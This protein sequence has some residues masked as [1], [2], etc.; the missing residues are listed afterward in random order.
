M[1]YRTPGLGREEL[2]ALGEVDA[3]RRKLRFSTAEPR[4]WVGTVRRVLAAR[5]IQA[6]NSIEGYHLSVEDAIA[7]VDGDEPADPRSVEARAVS[8]YQRAMTYV[9][10]LAADDHFAY[11][12]DLLRSL[13]F[14]IAEYARDAW[15]GRWRP[16]PI[17]VRDSTSGDAVYEA[18]EADGVPGLVDELVGSLEV[19]DGSPAPVRAAMAHLNLVMIHPFRDGNGRMSRCL[20]TLVLAREGTLA[21]E[22]ISIEEYLGR[23]TSRYYAVLAEVGR[24]SWR[25]DGDARGWVRFCLEAHY[26]QAASVLRRIEESGRIWAEIETLRSVRSLP[27]RSTEALFDATIGLQVRNAAY[28]AVLGRRGEQISQ[29]VATNDLRALVEAGLLV[30]HGRNRG[31]Y[32]VA[33]EPLRALYVAV[34][35]GRRP[36][37]TSTLFVPTGVSDGDE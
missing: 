25:P 20:Q 24:G 6:S 34:R 36:I 26:V 19:T 12:P 8:S 10:G 33:A 11:S 4:R 3:L 15:P 21:Q 31:A 17:W 18:P 14:M 32:Y 35:R 27:E 30:A 16:G 28:R 1:I 29:Q 23:N 7:V 13:H 2:A 22:L 37:D 9:I 5:A